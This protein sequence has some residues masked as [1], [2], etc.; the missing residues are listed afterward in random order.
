MFTLL[1]F[2]IVVYFNIREPV[3][4]LFALFLASSA[5]VFFASV[6]HTQFLFSNH[7]KMGLVFLLLSAGLVDFSAA[8]FIIVLLRIYLINPPLYRVWLALNAMNWR[9]IF[10]P[11]R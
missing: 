9:N 6:L 8:V 5:S 4:L 3:Y 10:L 1:L 2:F 7:I 11:L